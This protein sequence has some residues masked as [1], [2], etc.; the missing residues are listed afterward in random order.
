MIV[1]A[2]AGYG[3]KQLFITPSL[4]M[5]FPLCYTISPPDGDD[6]YGYNTFDFG[7][8]FDLSLQYQINPSW[9]LFGGWRASDDT[10]FSIKYGDRHQDYI[11]G[12]LSIAT[13]TSRI[14]IGFMRTLSTQKWFKMNRRSA[15]FENISGTKN[16]DVLYLILFKL[17]MLAGISYNNIVPSTYENEL[18]GFSYGTYFY[19]VN[20][21]N[22]FSSF[23]GLNL[24]FFNYNKNHLQLTVLYSQGLTHVLTAD[25][26]YQLPSG[27]YEATLGSRG[28]Y[29]SLQL[30]YPIKVY[31]SSR[32]KKSS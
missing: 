18:R 2:R 11:E 31:D 16:E 3:Q 7:A 30:G 6:G 28:S 21:R 29:I 4:G 14:P 27:N 26:A 20:S 17:R 19:S 9:I 10:G 12:R 24:Q 1:F 32:K 8:S 13:Y 15:I 23:F 22:S 5:A 25:V